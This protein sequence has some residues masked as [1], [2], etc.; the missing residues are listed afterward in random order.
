MTRAGVERPGRPTG[1]AIGA[2]LGVAVLV[3]SAGYDPN[4]LAANWVPRVALFYP[5]VAALVLVWL[6]ARGPSGGFDFDLVDV[7]VAAFCLWQV[8]AALAAPVASIAW[9]GAYNRVG[10]VVW[11]LALGAVLFVARRALARRVTLEA[12][13][14]VI[15]AT[16]VLAA[17]VA[18]VQAFGGDMWWER[19]PFT[20]GRMPGPTGNPVSLGGLGLL[21]VLLGALALTPGALG[22]PARWASIVGTAAGLAVVVLSVSRA[23][24][25][26]LLVGGVTLAVVWGAR[27]RRRALAWLAAAAAATALATV[28]YAPNGVGGLLFERISNQAGREGVVAGQVDAKRVAYWRVALRA[29][30][31]RPLVGYGPGG[32]VVAYRRYVPADVIQRD[33][34]S[35]V[36]DPHGIVFLVA[37]GSGLVGLALA[38]LLAGVVAFAAL[39]AGRENV[40]HGPPAGAFCLAALAFL[41]VSPTEP[42]VVLPLV[43]S[44]GLLAPPG[45]LPRVMTWT[46]ER[47]PVARAAW[48]AAVGLAVATGAAAVSLGAS[49]WRADAAY[50]VAV[51]DGDLAYAE[52]AASQTPRMSR[53]QILAGKLA[54]QTAVEQGGDARLLADG[55]DY[56]GQALELDATDPSPRVDLAKLALQQGDVDAAMT[57]VRAGLENNPHHPVLQA[58]WGYAAVL[59]ARGEVGAAQADELRAG[60]EAY[61][62]KVADAW[63]WLSLAAA[64]RGDDEAAAAAAAAEAR[65]LAP[66]LTPHDYEARLRG[67][68]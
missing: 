60:L 42:A 5:L 45:A 44:V 49:L 19:G 64:A 51:D 13:V 16:V 39:R 38:C 63:Y 4:V 46:G 26:G 43:V 31:E 50:R 28:L 7:A 32:Y 67:G 62:D 58:V 20:V 37:A 11:W 14:W 47:R 56:L 40:P 10:G 61:P 41:A 48:L 53:Y 68:A 34:L 23:A 12:F 9:F 2:L 27:R 30:R 59:A 66:G 57:E 24:Y 15:A 18:L 17:V 8:V 21:A 3:V 65:R 33:P 22:R 36:T 52:R 6:A 25:L 35:A 1:A 55:K 54:L 29:V